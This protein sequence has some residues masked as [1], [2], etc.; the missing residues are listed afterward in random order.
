MNSTQV[1]NSLLYHSASRSSTR[2]IEI[3]EEKERK[4][5]K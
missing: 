4:T 2:Q 3:K 5:S 1:K